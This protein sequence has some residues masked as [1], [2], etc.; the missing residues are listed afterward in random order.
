MVLVSEKDTISKGGKY[1]LDDLIAGKYLIIQYGNLKV[2]YFLMDICWRN[3][4]VVGL[5]KKG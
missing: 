3:V 1:S 4:I 5:K 2:D